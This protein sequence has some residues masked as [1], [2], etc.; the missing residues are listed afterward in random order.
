MKI[1]TLIHN[2]IHESGRSHDMHIVKMGTTKVRLTYE[3]YNAVERFNGEIFDGVKWNNVFAM[4]DLGVLPQ[5]SAYSRNELNR[6][7]I[8]K[9]L[10]ENAYKYLNALL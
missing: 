4:E 1:E 9:L 5:S 7:E 3:A 2:A 6:I 8:V 10:T